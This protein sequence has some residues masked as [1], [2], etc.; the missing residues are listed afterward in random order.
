MYALVWMQDGGGCSCC[1]Q[2]YVS[3]VYIN[4]QPFDATQIQRDYNKYVHSQNKIVIS[5][6]KRIYKERGGK[7]STQRDLEIITELGIRI[8]PIDEYL[9]KLGFTKCE[10]QV[11]SF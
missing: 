5:E 10:F 1:S 4:E 7:R 11:E 3:A 9:A 2:D 8:L 6:L